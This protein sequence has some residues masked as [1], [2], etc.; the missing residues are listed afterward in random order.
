MIE[1][2]DGWH[3]MDSST[4]KGQSEQCFLTMVQQFVRS[5]HYL[6]MVVDTTKTCQILYH[7]FRKLLDFYNSF[8]FDL[9]R[10]TV[11]NIKIADFLTTT[12]RS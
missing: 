6:I 4:S 1:F 11:N 8:I 12:N 2:T 3:D 10:H 9:R 7:L 5:E